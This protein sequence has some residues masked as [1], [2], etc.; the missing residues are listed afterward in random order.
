[1][2]RGRPSIDESDAICISRIIAESRKSPA[3]I[4]LTGEL[5]RHVAF[6]I[7]ATTTGDNQ[8]HLLVSPFV[9]SFISAAYE[10]GGRPAPT[11]VL[12]TGVGWHTAIPSVSSHRRA[13]TRLRRS[14]SPLT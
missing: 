7:D 6:R 3:P 11:S 12:D 8:G 5:S 13:T 1:M 9:P 2:A 14:A 4:S 10:G